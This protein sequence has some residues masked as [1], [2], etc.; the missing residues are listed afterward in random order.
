MFSSPAIVVHGLDHA[1]AALRPALPVTL[2]SAPGAAMWAGCGWWR[3]L[4]EAARAEHPQTPCSDL[5]DCGDAPGR[6]MEALRIGLRG[7]VLDP[8]CPAFPAVAAAG[9][10]LGATVLPQ[11]PI[12]LD[13]AQPGADRQIA[14]WLRGDN[15]SV[16]G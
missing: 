3:A 12:S 8:A 13:L 4:V 5:L 9:S 14:V 2:L 6:A 11:R 7:L 15:E 1:R 16:P 10:L